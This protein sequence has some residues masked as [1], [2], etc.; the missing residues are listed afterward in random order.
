MSPSLRIAA[1]VLAACAASPGNARA[2]NALIP[3]GYQVTR[4]VS[5]I[6]GKAAV[7]DP[8]LVNPWGIAFFPGGAFWINDNGTGL[9][10]LYTGAGS[11]IP[12]Y[13]V[14]PPPGGQPGPSAPTGIV[15]NTTQGFKVPGTSL[16]ALF[17]FSTEDG[18]I[19]AWAPNL[20]S[21]PTSAVLAVD[22]SAAG[23]VYKGLEFGV[24]AAG[25]FI[26]AT[27]FHGGTVDVFDNTFAPAANKLLGHFRDPEIQAGYAPFGIRN[28]DGDLFV[29]YAKQDSA[30]HDDVAG[31][32]RG[33]V[34]V[35]DTDGRLV[36]RFA[37]GGLLNSPWGVARAPLGFGRLS[38]LI[39][40]G[41]FGDGQVNSFDDRGRFKAPLED[42]NGRPIVLP[43]LWALSFGGGAAST[44]RTLFFTAGLDHE[45]H[46]LFGSIVPLPPSP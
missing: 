44:P 12:A 34:D 11:V 23:A 17:M 43:G 10:T 4:L 27:N 42:A 31:P 26:Y 41:N 29:T 2:Q 7:T 13:F 22:N 1:L 38:S 6:P 15:I 3:P 28:I 46:G 40:I 35:F 18:T 14:I 9:S 20:P 25:T 16:P 8:N 36:R 24:T 45:Q 30:K 39:L 33:Y 21:N 37:A 32:G 19:S 5:D